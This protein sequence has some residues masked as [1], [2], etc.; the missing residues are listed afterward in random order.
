MQ[1]T[2]IDVARIEN[3]TTHENME[4]VQENQNTPFVHHFPNTFSHR[5]KRGLRRCVHIYSNRT[6]LLPFDLLPREPIRW[7]HPQASWDFR[8]VIL[9]PVRCLRHVYFV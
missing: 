1:S 6:V 9:L 7:S 5:V 4:T 8:V 2:V 3:A